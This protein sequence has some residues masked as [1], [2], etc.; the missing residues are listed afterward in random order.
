[1]IETEQTVT[2]A[3]PLDTVWNFARDIRRW[4]ELMPGLQDCDVIDDDNS[5][6]TLKA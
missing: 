4:A 3:A 1:M 2:I 5:R 6:W